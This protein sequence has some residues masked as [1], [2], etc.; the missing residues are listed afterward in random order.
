MKLLGIKASLGPRLT[1]LIAHDD[2]RVTIL[3]FHH[4]KA[5]MFSGNQPIIL[6]KLIVP[7]GVARI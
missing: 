4:V 6:R 3:E 7:R 2:A 1:I 5:I